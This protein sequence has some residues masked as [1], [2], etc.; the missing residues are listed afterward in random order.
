MKQLMKMWNPWWTEGKVTASK[1]RIL[2]PH[3][4]ETILKLLDIREII[5]ITGGQEVREV[6]CDVPGDRLPYRKRSEA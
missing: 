4:L 2:R 6:D 3:T 1:K 5:C